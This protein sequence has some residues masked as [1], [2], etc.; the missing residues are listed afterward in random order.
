[1]ANTIE[2]IMKLVD[3]LETDEEKVDLAADL[4]SYFDVN[5]V[6]CHR[7]LSQLEETDRC[8]LIANL[9]NYDDDGKYTGPD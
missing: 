9:D 7:F 4:F 5:R 3:E 2:K 6:N 8:E 1:M